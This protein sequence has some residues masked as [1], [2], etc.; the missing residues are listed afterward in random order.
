MYIDDVDVNELLDW[1][2]KHPDVAFIVADGPG[3]WIARNE[4]ALAGDSRFCI[5]H[6]PSGPLP[7]V[8]RQGYPDEIV[9]APWT[10]WEERRQGADPRDP[11]FGVGHP[12]V[13]WWNV[14]TKS[15]RTDGI[16]LSSFEWIGNHYKILGNAAPPETEAFWKSLRRLVKSRHAIR[17][18]RAGAV[19][20]PRPE[21][22]TF[23]SA[24]RKIA[25]GMARDLNPF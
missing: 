6:T 21:I 16:G 12:G 13:I 2:N 7:L 20:W 15:A 9:G 18:P 22:W 23:P 14:K 24:Y 4:I 8:G 1:L 10:G 5:W 11:Y 17:V 19:N 25:A 3:R